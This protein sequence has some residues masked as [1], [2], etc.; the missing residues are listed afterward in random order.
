MNDLNK[1]KKKTHLNRVAICRCREMLPTCV[2]ECVVGMHRMPKLEL[3]GFSGAGADDFISC[4]LNS[5][6]PYC[7]LLTILHR[8]PR[9]IRSIKQ[10]VCV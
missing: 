2:H 5:N 6:Q 10:L 4:L 9:N 7:C 8:F 1:K 3:F